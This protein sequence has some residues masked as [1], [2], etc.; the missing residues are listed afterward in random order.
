MKLLRDTWLVFQRHMTLTF[1]T[2]IW[3][4]LGVAQPVVYLIL[5]APLLKP[6]L[7]SLGSH[8]MADA[9]RI[10][11]PGMLVALPSGSAAPGLRPARRG[12]LRVI[13]RARV[14]PISRTALL[15]GRAMRDVVSLIVQ[16]GIIT[17]LALPFGCSSTS[18]TCC[19]RS[20]CW[21]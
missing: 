5:F 1:R 4:V 21:P 12:A 11:V 16:A 9:Y 20:C 6:A 15:L 14:T 7:S 13:E 18:R 17:V 19:W 8:T 2:P 3:I 10:Y